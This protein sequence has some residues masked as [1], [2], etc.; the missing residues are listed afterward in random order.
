MACWYANMSL[1]DKS[2]HDRRYLG[3][4]KGTWTSFV[5]CLTSSSGIFRSRHAKRLI[6][7]QYH[8]ERRHLNRFYLKDFSL[9][10]PFTT[11][12]TYW[13][14]F[15]LRVFIGVCHV[16]NSRKLRLYKIAFNLTLLTDDQQ[17]PQNFTKV[18]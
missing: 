7:I 9:V 6:S 18:Y 2:V 17:L 15:L 8:S 13:G 5:C 4:R 1:F 12:K 14:L 10:S 16:R 11:S 3:E